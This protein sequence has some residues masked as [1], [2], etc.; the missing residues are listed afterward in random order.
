MRQ[1]F[2][3]EI[4]LHLWCRR[5]YRAT[6][7]YASREFIKPPPDARNRVLELENVHFPDLSARST[8]VNPL[9]ARLSHFFTLNGIFSGQICQEDT[10]QPRLSDQLTSPH[11]SPSSSR[12]QGAK[13][14]CVRRNDLGCEP[15]V[16]DAMCSNQEV[17]RS[18]SFLERANL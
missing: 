1:M 10:L 14:R 2:A 13:R 15:L 12:L 11:F 7:T 6:S 4:K 5:V 17:R 16:A 8:V 18:I 3:Q 9:E